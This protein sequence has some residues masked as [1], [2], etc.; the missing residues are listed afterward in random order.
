MK[1]LADTPFC[2]LCRLRKRSQTGEDGATSDNDISPVGELT[3]TSFTKDVERGSEVV[4]IGGHRRFAAC[5]AFRFQEREDIVCIEI[6]LVLDL[7]CLGETNRRVCSEY[8]DQADERVAQLWVL[9]VGGE[10]TTKDRF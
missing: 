3:E 6:L 4:E 2:L 8:I 1:V 7:A 10:E 5:A 9:P